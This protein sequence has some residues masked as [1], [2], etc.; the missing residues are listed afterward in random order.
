[1][2]FFASKVNL[3]YVIISELVASYIPLQVTVHPGKLLTDHFL[4][5]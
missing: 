4:E 2:K 3:L 1:M 5:S